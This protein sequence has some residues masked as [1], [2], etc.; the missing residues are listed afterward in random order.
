MRF[1]CCNPRPESI[2]RLEGR[3]GWTC[4]NT[5]DDDLSR[6]DAVVVINPD[7]RARA[8]L[9]RWAARVR[10]VAQVFAVD[11]DATDRDLLEWMDAGVTGVFDIPEAAAEMAEETPNGPRLSGR[12]AAMEVVR[13]RIRLVAARTCGVLIEGE[14]GTGKELVARAIHQESDRRNGPWITVNCAAIPE[15]LLEAELFGHVKGAFTGAIQGRAGKFEAANRGTIFLDEI[16][17]MPMSVQS[18]LLRVLQEKE[19]ERLGGNERVRLDVRVIAATNVRLEQSV[20]EGRFRQ[21]LFYR[22]NVVRIPIAPLRSRANDVELLA[23]KFL[24]RVCQTE[25]MALKHYSAEALA[26]L[27]AHDWPGNVRELEHA[28]E[29]AAILSADR[30]ILR[31]DDFPIQRIEPAMSPVA[32]PATGMD[33]QNTVEEF[34]RA[35]LTQALTRVRGNKTAAAELLG[36]KRT[37]L[38]AKLKIL[39][40]R[41]PRLVA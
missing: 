7:N 41:M 13:E 36:M 30:R 34:E 37:T 33:Y 5:L 12:S 17:D 6:Y 8:E 14:T 10:T 29:S 38:T 31:P 32:V 24:Q 25:S 2:S 40:N 4:S 11:A 21:D 1:L 23:R 18:K 19:V 20:R 27:T 35:L 26:F 15:P 16:G 22:L 3:N 39:Q 28:I 9:Q